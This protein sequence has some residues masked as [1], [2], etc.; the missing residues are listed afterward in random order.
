MTRCTDGTVCFKEK[1]Y[2]TALDNDIFFIF[3]I[4]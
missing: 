3:L 1:V 4:F 2:N